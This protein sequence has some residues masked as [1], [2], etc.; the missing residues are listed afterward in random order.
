MEDIDVS[1]SLRRSL[2]AEMA[3]T[4]GDKIWLRGRVKAVPSGDSLVIIGLG[5][6]KEQFPPE[7]TITLSS[8]VAPRLV[9]LFALY[10]SHFMAY[11][12]LICFFIRFSPIHIL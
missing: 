5:N 10:A 12:H 6:T 8:L 4:A 9:S 11:I 7:K 3:S 2:S 1:R